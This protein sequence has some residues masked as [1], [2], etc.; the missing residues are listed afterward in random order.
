MSISCT[1]I[2]GRVERD[3]KTRENEGIANENTRKLMSGDDSGS[4]TGSNQRVEDKVI[5]DLYKG[6]I[7]I[8]VGRILENQGVFAPR[9]INADFEVEITFPKGDEVMVAQSSESVAGYKLTDL[10]LKYKKIVSQE[11]YNLAEK[12]YISGRTIPF[13]CVDRY[14]TNKADWKKDTT[15][16]N[17][18]VNI[19][20]KS[21]N[22]IVMLF[23]DDA[24]DSEKFVYP[25]IKVI[26]ATI[27]GTTN[28]LYSG[29]SGGLTKSGMY[30]AARDF[31]LDNDNN[32]VTPRQFFNGNMFA[33]VIDLRAV[34]DK[35]IIA[36]GRE[37]INTQDGVL[38]EIEKE[39]TSKDLT[40]YMYVVS[41]GLVNIQ[42][43]NVVRVTK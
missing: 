17:M 5:A 32:T 35:N 38:I 4:G 18:R 37:I 24:K 40:C 11:L 33:A 1:R 22:A 15:L 21:M 10:K 9:V 13:K 6:E 16:V 36:N 3:R 23:W 14:E 12:S 25:K 42:D 7:V 43:K 39:A 34:N 27:D 20:R 26:K 30:K 19:P 28:A 2:C 29:E 41:D 31:F 8:P